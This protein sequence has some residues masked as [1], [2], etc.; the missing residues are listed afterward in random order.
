MRNI[1]ILGS[2]GSI[3]RQTL[4]VIRRNGD[5]FHALGLACG[6]NVDLLNEQIA[7]FHPKYV[8]ISDGT[9][10]SK[11]K[12][13]GAI[14]IDNIVE[15]AAIK[16]DFVVTAQVGIAGLL[17]TISSIKAGNNIALANKETLVCAGDLINRF[18]NDNNVK[19]LPVDSEHSAIWQCL[20]AGKTSEVSRLILTAS[21]GAFRGMK[22]DQ[23]ANIKSCEAL[24]HPTWSMGSK[25]T[26]DSATLMNKGLEIIEARHLFNMGIDSIDVIMHRQS[27]IHSMVEYIDGNVIAQM[28]YPTMELPIQMAIG[29]PD[30]IVHPIKRLDFKEIARL[31]FEEL[32]SDTFQCL[33]IAREVGLNGGLNPCI[34]NSANE[35]A[36]AAYL[37]N[38]IGFLDIPY[39]ISKVLDE[40]GN[41]KVNYSIDDV[42]SADI[43]ARALTERL[44]RAHKL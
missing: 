18:A 15:L 17:P 23:L 36:V 5:K 29:Y 41:S 7:E 24:K 30:R 3:G 19:L 20:S 27:I 35:I 43:E 34:M 31:D 14:L 26:I 33:N 21:G 4:N 40:L 42:L 16:C 9:A 1:I 22:P 12:L 32:D 37:D 6:R 25:I 28:S 10:K 11:V 13:N 8:Y 39:Y 38:K 44:I 2:T